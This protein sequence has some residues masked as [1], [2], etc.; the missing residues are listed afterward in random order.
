MGENQ[1]RRQAQR[2]K[3][4]LLRVEQILHAAG[5]LF[6]EVGYDNTTTNMIAA[7]ASI[8]P[9]SLYQFFPDKD[10]IA[11][12]FAADV[13]EQLHQVYD[14]FLSLEVIALPLQPFLESFI[15]GIVALIK[16][17]L[18]ILR[19]RLPQPFLQPLLSS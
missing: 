12:A 17:I 3:R 7:R 18:A 14:T 4:G 11:Q 5:D 2:Q 1:Q 16:N 8:S 15:D 19:L 10:A 9:G 6:A 13:T